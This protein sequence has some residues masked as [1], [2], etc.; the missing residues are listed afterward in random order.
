MK[1]NFLGTEFHCYAYKEADASKQ[2]YQCISINYEVNILGL[3]GPRKVK[4][5]APENPIPSDKNLM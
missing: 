2:K 4:V 3:N 5:F 1:S